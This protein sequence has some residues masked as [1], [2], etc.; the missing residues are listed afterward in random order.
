MKANQKQARFA[1]LL[2]GFM[3]SFGGIGCIVTGL[4]FTDI[5]LTA[6]AIFCLVT[7]VITTAIAGRKLLGVAVAGFL[8]AG[9]WSWQKGS[10]DLSLEAFLNQIS[11]LYDQGYG[12][13]V[14]RW[15][16]ET[17][18]ADMAQ[19]VLCALGV[20]TALGICWS[21][22]RCKDV[23]LAALLIVAPV[24]P[25]M[26]LTDTV[27]S[28]S[29]L[30]IQLMCLVLLLMIRLARKRN[31]GIALLKLLA[32]PVAMAV[33]VLFICI[34]QK[35][36][37]SFKPVDALL[38]YIQ[39]FF[40]NAGNAPPQTPAQQE[41]RWVNLSAVGPKRQRR[42][43]VMDVTA[44]QSGY[45]Y[46]RGAAYDTYHSTWWDC[47]ENTPVVS[48]PP[49]NTHTVTITTRAI[50][51][52][53]YLPY[54]TYGIGNRHYFL[55][56]ED[57]QVAN[58]NGWRSYTAQYQSLPDPS[59]IWQNPSVAVSSAYTQ[60]PTIT[61][62]NAIAYLNRELPELQA[63]SASA[64][65]SRAQAIVQ[66]VSRSADYSLQTSKMP[67]DR[68]FALW[69]LEESDT[70]YCIHFATAAAVLLR[71]AEIPCRYVTGYL[72]SAQA[73]H[74]V[75]VKQH[76][77]HAW[78][79]C[80]IE[81]VGW[82]PLEP[83]PGNGLSETMGVETTTPTE[84]PT[85]TPIEIPTEPQF[86]ETTED[87]R[88]TTVP[89]QTE[90]TTEN[91]TLPDPTTTPSEGISNVGGA[92]R[93][94]VNTN[95]PAKT[96]LFK[97]PLFTWTATI[98]CAIGVVLGQWRLRVTLR[99]KKCRRGKRNAQTLARWQLV[100]LHCRIRKEEPDSKLLELAQKARFSHHA[101]TREEL[102]AFEDWLSHSTQ[103]F[104]TLNLWKRFLA[105]IILALY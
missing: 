8:I 93:P 57:G 27:P 79:E 23:W 4:R 33:L 90:E 94:D 35:S 44:S 98:L 46:L 59:N 60:L 61:R 10:L 52:V 7:A 54:G 100:V 14:I 45:L 101:V 49:T 78:V 105:T 102:Q 9:L 71:A 99:Q 69:F 50:H 56:E 86:T 67:N 76:N 92:D 80:Y 38:G 87:T 47:T 29:F 21:F 96:P 36:Y 66:H 30:F 75:E 103:T 20:L 12:W 3:G 55:P 95:D 22:L 18:T 31:Q 85:E 58:E 34:P 40:T 77:A 53:L 70:G 25:C 28:A 24:V 84:M 17:L 88:E 39:E 48:L 104:H 1:A 32:L 63:I 81:G 13:G 97:T 64:L 91:T 51:D 68:D 89:T 26:V 82:V 42:G 5:S 43:V 16:T 6:I 62:Q 72:V 15:S 2:L 65:W 41:G 74:A 11:R 37:A 73:G 83:T 19:P